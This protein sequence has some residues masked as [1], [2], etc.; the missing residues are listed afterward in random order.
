MAKSYGRPA[1]LL[2]AEARLRFQRIMVPAIF[3]LVIGCFMAGALIGRADWRISVFGTVIVT[4][5]ICTVGWLLNRHV[6]KIAEERRRFLRGA[7]GEHLVAWLLEDL[8]D[9]WHIFHSVRL[10]P[11][12]DHDHIL[13][14]PPGVLY[15]S[16]KNHRGLFSRSAAGQL[17]YN[18]RPTN[19][20]DQALAQ[21]T[22]L[23][24]RLRA[25]MGTAGVYVIAILC[26][27]FGFVDFTGTIRNVHVLHQ[28]NLIDTLERLPKRLSNEQLRAFLPVLKTLIANSKDWTEAAAK[29]KIVAP[30]S[31]SPR[32]TAPQHSAATGNAP[33]Q[34]SAPLPES[35]R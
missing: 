14:G 5:L 18:N 19:T 7:A 16:T 6:D 11:R 28:D 12:G 30:D 32:P 20:I 4:A 2:E 9:N 22:D 1:A 10:R 21:S 27:P 34:V 23:A 13:L 29:A 35:E 25:L 17:L 3:L 8:P 31:V 26:V 15:V 24:E 33:T